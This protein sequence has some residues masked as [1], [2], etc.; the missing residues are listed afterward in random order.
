[1][2]SSKCITYKISRGFFLQ[3]FSRN[4]VCVSHNSYSTNSQK[5][6][7]ETDSWLYFSEIL[8]NFTVRIP[9]R[10]V[11]GIPLTIATDV[12]MCSM[13]FFKNFPECYQNV[14]QQF[15]IGTSPRN[16]SSNFSRNSFRNL[17]KFGVN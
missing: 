12:H 4:V 6:N 8:P 16:S 1:M 9:T 2:H 11:L 10:I 13:N 15:F 5:N 17:S 14:I 3:N 7:F